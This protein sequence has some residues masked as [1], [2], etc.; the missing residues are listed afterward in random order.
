MANTIEVG[1]ILPQIEAFPDEKRIIDQVVTAFSSGKIIDKQKTPLEAADLAVQI[2]VGTEFPLLIVSPKQLLEKGEI[3]VVKR[4]TLT[5]EW[6][7]VTV[8][9]VPGIETRQLPYVHVRFRKYD[10][11]I[12]FDSPSGLTPNNPN[13]HGKIGLIFN[14]G[15]NDM[16]PRFTYMSGWDDNGELEYSAVF[17]GCD[18][19]GPNG[20]Y[21]DAVVFTGRKTS[22]KKI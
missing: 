15:T 17:A 19:V 14:D 8:I 4:N 11:V 16:W 3:K 22:D 7:E 10:G 18:G 21:F 5:R 20:S 6:D 13:S 2:V 12:H 9:E 1:K